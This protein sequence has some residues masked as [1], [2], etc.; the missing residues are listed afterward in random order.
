MRSESSSQ[1]A[2][3]H[4]DGEELGVRPHSP[5][6]AAGDPSNLWDAMGAERNPVA[7]A[8]LCAS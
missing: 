1:V 5:V 4:R 7:I 2:Q 3:L 6:V 8:M